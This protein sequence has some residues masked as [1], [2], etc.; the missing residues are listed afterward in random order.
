[1]VSAYR[2]DVLFALADQIEARLAAAQRQAGRAHALPPAR[3]F[4]GQLVRQDPAR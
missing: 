2:V 4:A 1:M 3:A